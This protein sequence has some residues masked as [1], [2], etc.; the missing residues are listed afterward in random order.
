M[1]WLEAMLRQDACDR[2][3]NRLHHI[4]TFGELPEGNFPTVF[5]VLDPYGPLH[6][7]QYG[8]LFSRQGNIAVLR[9]CWGGTRDI[10]VPP[11]TPVFVGL[12][13]D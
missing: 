3:Y 7:D 1:S 10:E 8:R 4:N 12:L 13:I 2:A 5:V 6:D 9:N 11:D